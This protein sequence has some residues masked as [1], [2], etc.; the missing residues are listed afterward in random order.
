[1]RTEISR[2]RV[3]EV[4]CESLIDLS[5]AGTR[6]GKLL[7]A[8]A[9]KAELT[10]TAALGTLAKGTRR[11]GLEKL[12]KHFPE[13]PVSSGASSSVRMLLDSCH[14]IA[15]SAD[16]LADVVEAIQ[17]IVDKSDDLFD[18]DGNPEILSDRVRKE[19]DEI[20]EQIQDGLESWL[21]ARLPISGIF[22]ESIPHQTV[23]LLAMLMQ[24]AGD[25]RAPLVPVITNRFAEEETKILVV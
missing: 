17:Q 12:R 24:L 13:I 22:T 18:I 3:I 8:Y 7:A 5:L 14:S 1:M 20:N 11:R 4:A 19:L 21:K 10:Q 6:R 9:E 25:E 23:A 16:S 2:D 15:R